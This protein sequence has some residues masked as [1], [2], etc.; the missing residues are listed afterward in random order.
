M[1]VPDRTVLYMDN[2]C[3]NRPYDNQSNERIRLESEAKMYI[4][5]L[6]KLGKIVLAWSFILD[7][8]NNANPILERKITIAEW[9]NIATL[10]TAA[11]DEIRVLANDIQ[12]QTK[13]KSKD[14]LHIAC[15]LNLNSDYLLTTDKKMLKAKINGICIINPVDFVL[16]LHEES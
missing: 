5:D 15:A 4:Q 2:C 12:N 10:Y 9:K 3:F 13:L 7:F 6:I 1:S 16:V 14:A 8:E 11:K